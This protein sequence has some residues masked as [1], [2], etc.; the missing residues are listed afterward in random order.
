MR[1]RK[2]VRSRSVELLKF[3]LEWVESGLPQYPYNRVIKSYLRDLKGKKS[4]PSAPT[5]KAKAGTG[6]LRRLI[7]MV[8]NSVLGAKVLATLTVSLILLGSY[9][10]ATC[11]TKSSPCTVTLCGDTCCNNDGMKCPTCLRFVDEEGKVQEIRSGSDG[12][13][14][15]ALPEG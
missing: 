2:M 12:G 15:P 6:F 5:V 13:D 3:R 9:G 1:L 10:C 8:K 14:V 7:T 11:P 4:W